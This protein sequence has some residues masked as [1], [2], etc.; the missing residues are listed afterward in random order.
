MAN[1]GGRPRS[2]LIPSPMSEPCSRSGCGI[3]DGAGIGPAHPDRIG[4]YERAHGHRD[5][6]RLGRTS[7]EGGRDPL[8]YPL[9]GQGHAA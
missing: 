8:E 7:L 2:H 4:G 1:R 3:V 5:C 9:D 6:P